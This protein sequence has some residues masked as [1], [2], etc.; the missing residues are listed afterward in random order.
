MSNMATSD[1]GKLVLALLEAGSRYLEKTVAFY[2]QSLAEGEK[3][4]ILG[5]RK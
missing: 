3:L 5:N 2:S 4:A 1:T